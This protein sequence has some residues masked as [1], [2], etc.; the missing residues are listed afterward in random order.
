MP[1][2]AKRYALTGE[3]AGLWVRTVRVLRANGIT[4]R[5]QLE[6]LVNSGEPYPLLR[7]KGCGK[8][9]SRE[10]TAWLRHPAR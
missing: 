3:F 10:L 9:L 1:S 6:A 7:L 2:T 4:T 8:Y 5:A